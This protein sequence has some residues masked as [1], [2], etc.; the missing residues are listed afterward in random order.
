M[1][2][3]IAPEHHLRHLRRLAATARISIHWQGG[4]WIKA[5]WDD[6]HGAWAERD[7]GPYIRTERAALISALGL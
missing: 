3:K 6:H 5:T 7:L 4:Q 2:K 1:N